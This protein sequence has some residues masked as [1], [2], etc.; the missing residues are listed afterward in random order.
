MPIRQETPLGLH[1]TTGTLLELGIQVD[2][3]LFKD[4]VDAGTC[5]VSLTGRTV[6][7]FAASVARIG[8]DDLSGF[9]GSRVAGVGVVLRLALA[10]GARPGHRGVVLGGARRRVCWSTC[11]L[12][13]SF[14]E[15]GP[16]YLKQHQHR[17]AQGAACHHYFA[18]GTKVLELCL[19]RVEFFPE[20]LFVDAGH[21]PLS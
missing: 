9:D 20:G 11:W 4:A 13:A 17:R 12:G 10:F 1:L 2:H 19:Y 21:D 6:E 5:F 8:V 15:Y 3:H 18:V 7:V 16:Q 14:H